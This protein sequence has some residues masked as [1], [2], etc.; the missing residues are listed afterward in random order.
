M[1]SEPSSNEPS[2]L[3]ARDLLKNLQQEFKVIRDFLP[4][5]IGINKQLVELQPGINRKLM[6]GALG[7]HTKSVRYLKTMQAAK[8]RFN[9][10]GTEADAVSDEQRAFASQILREYFKKRSDQKKALLAAK[11]AEEAERKRTEK[12]NQLRDKF[13]HK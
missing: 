1:T 5:A 6:R 13:S 2:P 11:E 7:M 4:L 8:V 3:T 12:L 9:L 10:D